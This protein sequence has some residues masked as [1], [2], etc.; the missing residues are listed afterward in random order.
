[1]NKAHILFRLVLKVRNAD[2]LDGGKYSCNAAKNDK[3]DTADFKVAVEIP[4][5]PR[6]E[7]SAAKFIV[8]CKKGKRG[9]KVQFKV[10]TTDGS[11]R[12]LIL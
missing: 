12:P 7:V 8:N 2:T 10:K 4:V 11:V 1:M 3:T 5:V 9:C 6:V